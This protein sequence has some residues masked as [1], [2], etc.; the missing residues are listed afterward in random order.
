[1]ETPGVEPGLLAL[2][3]S[4]KSTSAKPPIKPL[5]GIKPSL[6]EYETDVLS[7]DDNGRK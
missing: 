7:L 5:E 1:M 6:S 2:Q 3:A 4:A